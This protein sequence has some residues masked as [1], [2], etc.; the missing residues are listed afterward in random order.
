MT[1]LAR[2]ALDHSQAVDARLYG[3]IKI[4]DG[5]EAVISLVI[6]I[7]Q[8]P[9]ALSRAQPGDHFVVA[10]VQYDH[11]GTAPKPLVRK[12]R[13]HRL[14]AYAHTICKDPEFQSWA[15]NNVIAQLQP[16]GLAGPYPTI[17]SRVAAAR[18]AILAVCVIHN[19]GALIGNAEACD[20]FERL[21]TEFHAA[22]GRQFHIEIQPQ[23]TVT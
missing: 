19:R 2:M 1:A 13:G 22:H 7:D 11:T 5:V 23:E 4:A 10:V 3:P 6:P 20:R 12:S 17:S 9:E 14:N 21:V 18:G 16:L 15:I 8:V